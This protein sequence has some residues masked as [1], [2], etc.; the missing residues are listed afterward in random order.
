M[1][2]GSTAAQALIFERVQLGLI[3]PGAIVTTGLLVLY[4]YAASRPVSRRHLDRVSFRLLVHAL[5]AHLVFCIVFP[6]STINTRP[7]VACKVQA[8]FANGSLMFSAFMFFC[9]GINLPLVLAAKVNGQRMEKF[10]I[11]GSSLVCLACNLT[12]L[13]AGRFGQNPGNFTCWYIDPPGPTLLKW[14]MTTQTMWLLFTSVG[15]VVSFI[16]IL[17]YLVG[18]ELETRS[19]RTRLRAGKDTST[20]TNST[21]PATTSGFPSIDLAMSCEGGKFLSSGTEATTG[22]SSVP[23]AG[24]VRGRERAREP[25]RSSIRMFRGIVLRIGLYPLASCLLNISTSVM[26]WRT[27]KDPNITEE[28][29]RITTADLAIYCSRPLIYGLL[30]AT[31]PSFIRAMQALYHPSDADYEYASRIQTHVTR[32]FP[33]WW[34]R[35]GNARHQTRSGRLSTVYMDYESGATTTTDGYERE[36]EVLPR[37]PSAGGSTGGSTSADTGASNLKVDVAAAFESGRSVLDAKVGAEHER[38]GE[39][40]ADDDA[41]TRPP[42]V[43]AFAAA[44]VSVTVDMHVRRASQDGRQD[45]GDEEME[46]LEADREAVG[47]LVSQI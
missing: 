18:Y 20:A 2:S 7:G 3:I 38:D 35:H 12:P 25:T 42:R 13:A 8:F 37:M 21:T 33:W 40:A 16:V 19:F 9:V 30:A 47:W 41:R 5:V 34:W 46:Q 23:H 15:E 31:D 26:D 32:L 14:V 11:I 6:V 22:V 28:I 1:S 10:Y 17:V 36:L 27:S 43:V 45:H 24:R 44:P 39:D 29:W 4:A